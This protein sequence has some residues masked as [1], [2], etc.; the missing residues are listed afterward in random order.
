[1]RPHLLADKEGGCAKAASGMPMIQFSLVAM[2]ELVDEGVLTIERLVELMCHNPARLFSV[3]KRGFIKK[4]YKAD[5]AIVKAG[6]PW[7]VTPRPFRASADGARWRAM[8]SAGAS[9][10][11]SATVA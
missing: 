5:I 1:M 6:E 11:P 7:T 10:A 4:G 2:L 9:S 3:S 8:P